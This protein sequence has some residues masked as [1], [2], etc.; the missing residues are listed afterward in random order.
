MS[1][2]TQKDRINVCVVLS[3]SDLDECRNDPDICLNGI[4]RN[5]EGSYKCFCEDGY[6]LSQSG[7]F[8]VGKFMY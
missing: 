1:A 8:C 5:T 6:T 2:V 7:E 4:C 3:L